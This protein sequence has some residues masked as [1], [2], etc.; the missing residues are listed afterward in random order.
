MKKTLFLIALLSITAITYSQTSPVKIID[1]AVIPGVKADTLLQTDST[2]LIVNFKVKNSNQA[3]SAFF[4]FGTAQ[5]VGDIFSING[6]F[7]NQSGT[8]YLIT[9]GYQNEIADY[10]AQAFIK[11]S[12][13]Q[14]TDFNYLTVYVQD[15]SGLITDKLY[16]KK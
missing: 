2:D 14:N 5:D 13:Q 3:S 4:L 9:N 15:N 1:L 7:L 6:T 8:I 12:G 16:F 10:S 11:L